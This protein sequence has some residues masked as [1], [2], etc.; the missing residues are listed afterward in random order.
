M[1]QIGT[2]APE[3]SC[4]AVV[5]GQIKR[6]SLASGDGS[7]KL[8][9]FYPLDFTFVCP[10]ELHALQEKI[11]EFK[12]RNVTVAAVSIDS[13]HIHL[14]WLAVPKDKGGI[15]GITYPLLSDIT[16]SISLDYGVLNERVGVALRGTFLLDKDNI[17]QHATIN[18][19]RLGRNIDEFIRLIDALKHVEQYGE[20][21]PANWSDGKKAMKATKEGV[22]EYFKP[23]LM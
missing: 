14:A 12:K 21:C 16:K 7:Y 19:L 5:E 17:V 9:F 6:F 4:E 3:F 23:L 20:V 8:L 13:V 1:L 18:N 2:K 22:E 15:Q 10:T 11:L